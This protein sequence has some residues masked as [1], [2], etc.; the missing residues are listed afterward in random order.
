MDIGWVSICIPIEMSWSIIY[1][2]HS[3]TVI[4][5]YCIWTYFKVFNNTIFKKRKY[6]CVLL[7]FY[8]GHVLRFPV[9]IWYWS[10][11]FETWVMISKLELMILNHESWYGDCNKD[12]GILSW[13]SILESRH[14][15]SQ[16]WYWDWYQDSTIWNNPCD[17]DFA[18]VTAHLWSIQ[19]LQCI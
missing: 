15:K 1:W 3:C 4:S 11:E 18:R 17:W 2:I 19:Y 7:K 13:I 10:L 5:F 16:S 8:K 12:F 9:S 6:L 14:T